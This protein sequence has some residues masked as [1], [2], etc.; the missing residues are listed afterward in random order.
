M[1]E[2]HIKDK[3]YEEEIP[4]HLRDTS[5]YAYSVTTPDGG[6]IEDFGR[7]SLE[8]FL[9]YVR[10]KGWKIKWIRVQD[11]DESSIFKKVPNLPKPHTPEWHGMQKF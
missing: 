8:T 1:W 9:W 4:E 2:S 10:S 3:Y 6:C 7:M 5:N 11:G